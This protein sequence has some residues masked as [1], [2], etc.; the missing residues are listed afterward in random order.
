[1]TDRRF[2]AWAAAILVFCVALYFW[3]LGDIP[4]YTK[5]EPRE[6]V[7]MWEEVHSGDWILPLRNGHDLPSKPPLFH[8]LGGITGLVRG[9][10]DEFS[11]RFPS[12]LLAT[13]SVLLV[14]W[15]GAR[16]WGISAGVYAAFM[17]A[18]NFE[19]M[20]AATTSRVDMTLTACLIAAFVAFDR[21][22][23]AREPSARALV[24]F[25]LSMGL[26]ALAKGPVGIVLPALVALLYLALRGDW[27]RL[28][29]M[30]LVRGGAV[31][32][33][34]AAAWYVAAIGVGGSAFVWKHLFV[35][36]VGRFFAAEESGA[37][38]AHGPFYLVGGFFLG[39][40]PWSL[41]VVPLGVH[42]YQNRNRLEA[43]G[44]LYPLV[45]FC[46]VFGFYSLSESKRTVYL[47]PIYPAAALLI[48][49]WWSGIAERD[50]SLPSGV[51]RS[52]RAVS[53]A[54]ACLLV[55]VLALLVAVA[56]DS[57]PL[58]W[59]APW[60]HPKDRANL[61][62]LA[63]LLQGRFAIV[64]AWTMIL[65]PVIAL[66][67]WSVRAGRWALVFAAV[68]AFVASSLAVVNGVFQPELARRRTFKPFV[69]V[70]RDVVGPKDR[71]SFYRA[72]DYG[73]VFY[74]RRHVPIVEEVAPP[75]ADAL[76]YLLLWE[77][78]W[79]SLDPALRDRLQFLYRSEGTGP[80]GRDPLIFALV[81]PAAGTPATPTPAPP[82]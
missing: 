5:G 76:A 31:A 26:A 12:A 16:K 13:A 56:W 19:W 2:H 63:E 69:E 65:L 28:R 40:L 68:V 32:V 6:A 50:L 44:Y 58:S 61:P 41:F 66:F 30:N 53:I 54:M 78:E 10:V 72:F 25:Y 74:S 71:L 29:R 24:V 55:L 36:N 9:E 8:W 7:Q 1:M 60:L 17:L 37:G 43:Q 3:G 48:G 45:W 59:I 62:V 46:A 64:V 18:T 49:S 42:L 81:K 75:P 14:L 35:E 52:L 39:F 82:S 21:I 22:S 27:D 23:A 34:L 79:Q 57:T 11:A 38:H 67:A 70:V 20:R 77:S 47:L 4:F 51:A 33:A 80:K 73:V 15:L